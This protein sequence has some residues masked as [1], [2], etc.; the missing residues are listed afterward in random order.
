MNPLPRLTRLLAL[1]AA[2]A[3]AS[4]GYGQTQKNYQFSDKTADELQKFQTAYNAKNWDAALAVLDAQIPK[5]EP[6]S[7]D[8]AMLE[9]Y[10][11]QIFLQLNQYGKAIQP[12]EKALTL[13]DAK[14]PAFFEARASQ[15]FV[16]ILGQLYLQ[17]ATSVKDVA[18]ATEL[19]DKAEHYMSRWVTMN[20]KPT[21]DG[22][23]AFCTLLYSRAVQTDP[24]DAKRLVRALEYSDRAL[25]LVNRPKENLYVIKLA[26]L[27]QLNRN[28]EATEIL[29]LLLQQKPDNKTYWQQLAALN[30][31]LDRPIR[32]I[33]AM[34][35]AQSHGHLNTPKDNFNLI[36]IYFNIGQY[37]KAAELLETGLAK[38]TIENEQKNWELLSYSYQQLRQDDKSIDALKRATTV[39]PKAGQLEY[40]IAQA[41][42]SRE[43]PESALKH[44]QA[45][46]AKGNLTKPHQ[47]YLLVAWVAFELKNFDVALEA[48]TKAATFP[49]GAKEG[50]RMKS[51]IEEAKKDREAKLKA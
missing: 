14:S 22:M 5:A 26:C 45:A 11:A 46:V 25:R 24:P 50:A 37:E 47:A 10:R 27:L 4:A 41:Y 38:G 3:L 15:E 21:A 32:A 44:A 33:L 18:R 12:L 48:A 30:L 36:G 16:Y 35:R 9:Q 31:N 19:F 2:V 17:E 29:E 40:L 49:E 13:S 28:E 8:V 20:T 7:Y 34:E 6:G 23:Y 42:L 39:F 51:A 1:A 43:K